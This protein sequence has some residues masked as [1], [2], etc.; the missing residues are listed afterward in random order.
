[1]NERE[2]FT[3]AA[4]IDDSHLREQ[5]LVTVCQGDS[6]LRKR[7]KA[8]LQAGEKADAL[9]EPPQRALQHLAGESVVKEELNDLENQ[10]PPS[11]SDKPQRKPGILQPGT[12]IGNYQIQQFLGEGGMG[13]VYVAKQSEPIK[14]QVALKI[15][16]P[17]DASRSI[18]ARFEQERHALSMMEHPG[19][20]RILDAGSTLEGI[21]YFVMELIK[22]VPISQYCDQENLS[23]Q[24]RLQLFIPVCEAVQHAHQKGI[25]HRDLKPSNILIGLYDGKPVPKVI[26]FGVAKAVGSS[27]ADSSVYTE[28]GSVVGTLEYM[29]PEQAELNNLDIDTRADVYSLGV[30]L[31]ELLTGSPPFSRQQLRSA[32][33]DEMLRMIREVDPPKPSTKVSSSEEVASVAAHRKLEP[34]Q[35]AKA[36]SGDLDW[37]VMKSLAKERTRRYQSVSEFASDIDRFLSIQPVSA[38]PPSILYKASR[39]LKRNKVLSL[40]TALALF[41]M[42]AGGVAATLGYLESNRQ[43]EIAKQAESEERS[44]REL[45]EQRLRQVENGVDILSGVFDQ[46]NPEAIN[47]TSGDL[48]AALVE[49]LQLAA[50]QIQSQDLGDSVAVARLQYKLGLAL[51][52]LGEPNSALQ[53]LESAEQSFLATLGEENLDFLNCIEARALCLRRSGKLK[54][55]LELSQKVLAS[56]QEFLG[57][58]HLDTIAA[59]NNLGLTYG[60]LGESEK[61]ISNFVQAVE[62]LESNY[63]PDAPVTMTSQSNLAVYRLQRG[64]V[65]NSRDKLE[66]LL[67]RRTRIQGPDHPDTLEGMMSFVLALRL[68]G[69]LRKSLTVVEHAAELTRAKYGGDHPQ[70]IQAISNLAMVLKDLGDDAK[71]VPYLEQVERYRR[72]KLGS[73]HPSTL[74]AM[75]NLAVAYKESGRMEEAMPLYVESLEKRRRVLGPEHEDTLT[76]MNNLGTMYLKQQKYEEAI[77]L[78]EECLLL[79]TKTLGDNHPAVGVT[80]LNLARTFQEAGRLE[81]AVN[82]Y[83]QTLEQRQRSFASDHPRVLA[84]MYSLAIPLRRLKRFDEAIELIKTALERGQK[85]D[86]GLPNEMKQLPEMLAEVYKDAGRLEEAELQ[87]RLILESYHATYGKHHERSLLAQLS[88]GQLLL[89]RDKID[90]AENVLRENL[91]LRME[92]QPDNWQTFMSQ[93]VLGGL[94]LKKKQYAEAEVLLKE[95]FEGLSARTT[96]IPPDKRELR[97]SQVKKWLADLYRATD[98]NDEADK[99]VTPQ[100]SSNIEE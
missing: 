33:F 31:Y 23:P 74:Q 58:T 54:E 42:I 11:D 36:L 79:R 63:G 9:I 57:P 47:S 85:L 81:D 24:E 66:N 10:V 55:S 100:T 16:R 40:A 95:A 46:L 18:L 49:Q 75:A 80:Q 69:E 15:L 92:T 87:M 99:L 35:L 56:K 65:K 13:V 77:A 12:T 98:R 71:A 32:A 94:Q 17:S 91:D 59:I 64:D 8:L 52:K 53:V 7:I 73:E 68:N 90:E 86:G 20:A 62:L 88:L 29:A 1:M 37:V 22:G 78:L 2:I 14:R 96:L 61:A 34:K 3:A 89:Q 48:R 45:A 21:P 41:A 60:A 4:L 50:Q 26:D 76:S 84:A 38:G 70:T 25:I 19:I 43:F 72:L 93:G 83:R 67:E 27:L 6:Q 44:A 5:F 39:F 82:L 30:V 97:L 28:V 51:L